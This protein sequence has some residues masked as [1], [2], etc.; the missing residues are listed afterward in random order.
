L[1]GS[2]PNLNLG[3]ASLAG[4]ARRNE[5]LRS[6][7]GY[8]MKLL[9]L[10]LCAAGASLALG[11]S[12]HADPLPAPA[13]S[14]SLSANTKPA[15]FDA[16]PF[17]KISVGGAL[18]GLVNGQTDAVSPPDKDWLADLSNAQVWI[19]KTDGPVQF[20]VQ[21]GAY[22]LMS[23]GVPYHGVVD[24]K[25]AANN[26]FGYVPVA[27]I[28]LQPT[29]D[30]SIQAGKLPTLVGAEYTFTTENLNVNRG[31][32]WN[33]E[34]AVSRGV[35]AN[36]AHGPLTVSVSLTDGYYSNRYNWLT[37]L[38][39]YAVTKTDTLAFVGGGN[40]GS[41]PKSTFATIPALNN[42]EIYNVLW[43]HSQGNWVFNPYFQYT[44]TG[45]NPL[46][47]WSHSSST[48]GVAG[49]LKYSFTPEFNLAGRVEYVKQTGTAGDPLAPTLL[50]GPDSH[51]W[52][53]TVTPTYQKGIYFIRAD[54]AYTDASAPIFGSG[55]K[56]QFRF[57]AE[58]GFL[59]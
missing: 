5:T 4:H 27:F 36:Y 53:L 21:A 48:W 8:I 2:D 16:G 46:L 37:G 23:L 28:K 56:N 54:G 18:T 38:V 41:T 49:L 14:S 6:N 40:L 33:L 22:S 30:F 34:P 13:M 10:T 47:G 3:S 7:R 59:F 50:F 11:A 45:A 17:D 32:L 58:A 42:S 20:Y 25:N 1:I 44:H 9:K 52:S 12:A 35:Q 31:L 19:E 57:T 55:S 51:A 29:S 26:T 24:A 43:T 39:S 15:T